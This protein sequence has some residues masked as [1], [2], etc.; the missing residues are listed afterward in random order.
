MQTTI[1][2]KTTRIGIV[3]GGEIR[4]DRGQ[5]EFEHPW[6][7]LSSSA[8]VVLRCMLLI[9]LA[10]EHRRDDIIDMPESHHASPSEIFAMA[11]SFQA[12]E[13]CST[14]RKVVPMTEY[15]DLVYSPPN[16]S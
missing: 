8:S 1:I 10:E 11:R 6:F 12:L 9:F 2:A 4:S 16:D 7:N 13:C 5:L 14:G 3:E 15:S